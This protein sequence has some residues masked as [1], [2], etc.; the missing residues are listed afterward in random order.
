MTT[1]EKLA[2]EGIDYYIELFRER[3]M[4]DGACWFP[5][6]VTEDMNIWL[7]HLQLEEEV[8]GIVSLW[9][10]HKSSSPNGFTRGFFKKY[11]P[12]I[13]RDVMDVVYNLFNCRGSLKHINAT[14]VTL[15]LKVCGAT[16][17]LEF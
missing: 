13:K 7:C 12:I 16:H 15:T 1:R 10:P 4:I 5:L 11:W 14:F 3:T 17:K 8:A 2:I 9:A 6:L